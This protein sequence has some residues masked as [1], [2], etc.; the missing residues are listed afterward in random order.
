MRITNITQKKRT[1][2]THNQQCP[3]FHQAKY[4][5]QLMQIIQKHQAYQEDLKPTWK[6]ETIQSK[7]SKQRK[8]SLKNYKNQDNKIKEKFTDLCKLNRVILL[9]KRRN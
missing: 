6:S 7:Y 2:P 3:L 8:K 9:T 4:P 5:F 1:K